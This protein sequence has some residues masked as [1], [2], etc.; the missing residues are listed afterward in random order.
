MVS[1]PIQRTRREAAAG[2]GWY[3]AVARAG[4][5]AK[6]LSYGIVGVLSIKLAL[7]EGGKA[8]SR[9]GALH[10]LA[11]EPGGKVLLVLL[12]IGLA[13]YALW[14][15]VQTFAEH[16]GGGSLLKEVAKRLAY[17]GRGLVYAALTVSSVKIVLGSGGG[18]SQ[19][20]RAHKTTAVV[21]S[22][23]A[24]TWIVGVAGAVLIGIGL[25]NGYR[26]LTHRFE[27]RWRTGEI[28]GRARTWGRRVGVAGHLARA[29][30]FT[31]IG[32]FVVKA[33]IDYSS[34]AAVGLDGALQKLAR[35]PYGPYLL[36][37]TAAGL[38][39]YGL[40]CL[41]DARYRDVSSG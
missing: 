16:D 20:A 15:F 38:I 24:G 37:V 10:A 4:L 29:V 12:A 30:V 33:A 23:P 18:Q 41:V 21:L 14:R 6:G 2:K 19:N 31:L 26:G 32:V 1:H 9:P 25:W 17:L 11:R 3:A 5:V 8:T 39:C 35:A 36:G 28:S 13:C 34:R 22:W 40:Y 7:G 27:R